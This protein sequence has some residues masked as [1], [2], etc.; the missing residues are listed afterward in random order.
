MTKM[1]HKDIK[2][3]GKADPTDVSKI[4]SPMSTKHM[5]FPICKKLLQKQTVFSV[6]QVSNYF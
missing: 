2:D 5:L 6:N 3:I 4:L 1:S